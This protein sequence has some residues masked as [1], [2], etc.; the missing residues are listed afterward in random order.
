MHVELAICLQRNEMYNI[1]IQKVIKNR[2]KKVENA[3]SMDICILPTEIAKRKLP[4]IFCRTIFY[5][6]DDAFSLHLDRRD[7]DA[8]RA[9]HLWGEDEDDLDDRFDFHPSQ[10]KC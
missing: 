1:I 9:V 8:N 10:H 7:D 4:K 6:Y 5:H 2:Q 3:A